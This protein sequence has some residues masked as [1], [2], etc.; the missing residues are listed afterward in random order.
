MAK[1]IT[2]PRSLDRIDSFPL[3]ASSHLTSADLNAS[4]L[5]SYYDLIIDKY[6]TEN[7]YYDGQVIT[8]DDGKIFMIHLNDAFKILDKEWYFRSDVDYSAGDEILDSEHESLYALTDIS[9]GSSFNTSQ[10]SNKKV[11][12]ATSSITLTDD[13]TYLCDTSTTSLTLTLPSSPEGG[14]SI[15]IIDSEN[16]AS[17]NNLIID[18]NGE[19]LEGVNQ[20][21]LIDTDSGVLNLVYSGSTYGW[22]II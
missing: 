15:L 4:G 6:T 16:N 17:V 14:E 2:V 13:F 7:I 12:T 22:I 8:T 3:D 5:S 20:N 9:S 1:T 19:L 21:T 18:T 10:W 11:V